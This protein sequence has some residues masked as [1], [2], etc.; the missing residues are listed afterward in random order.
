MNMNRQFETDSI[1][2]RWR[3][4]LFHP[5]FVFGISLSIAG[6][7]AL[8]IIINFYGRTRV[9]LLYYDIPMV[10]PFVAYLFDRAAGWREQSL[11]RRICDYVAIGGALIRLITLIPPYSGHALFLTYAL[12]TTRTRLARILAAIVL[13]QVC[14]IKIFMWQD[15]T[16]IGG[17]LIGGIAAFVFQHLQ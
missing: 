16:I 8:F 10:F 9:F 5:L 12:F 2:I 14:Y 1:E 4:I 15:V 11:A 13:L 17:I 6:I 3:E 7:A